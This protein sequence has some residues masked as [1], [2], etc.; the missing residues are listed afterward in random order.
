ML[1]VQATY[2]LRHRGTADADDVLE[3]IRASTQQLSRLAGQLLTLARAEP[4]GR[5]PRQEAI[6]LERLAARVLEACAEPALA[7]D[8]D[9][10]LDA[11]GPV[12]ATA[13]A[14]MLGEAL[15]NLVDNAVHYCPARSTVTVAV[16]R[17]GGLA[18][19]SVQDNGPGVS[20][21]E[22]EHL[23]ERFYRVP[24]VSSPGSGLGLAI[25]KEVAEA[26]GGSVS[27]RV[28]PGGG[29]A[30][31]IRIPA[32]S[33]PAANTVMVEAGSEPSAVGEPARADD[34]GP[35]RRKLKAD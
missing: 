29:L 5:R 22:L 33:A 13:D 25:V 3:A 10:G 12:F 31:Q 7:K 35:M 27:A 21:D 20:P 16:G 1:N 4:G 14:A 6:D 24:G 2:A 23:F 28:V 17:R 30:V 8:I 18:V 19:L 15:T 26:A 11:A 32:A 9:L 34:P